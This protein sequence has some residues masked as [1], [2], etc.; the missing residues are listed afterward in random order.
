I[1]HCKPLLESA[2][3]AQFSPPL[4]QF[5]Q[6]FVADLP[7]VSRRG[8]VRLRVG[9]RGECGLWLDFSNEDIRDVL[10]EECWLTRTL[11]R[12]WIVEMGQRRKRVTAGDEG[13]RFR[14]IDPVLAP[15]F[16]TWVYGEARDLFATVGT[17]TQPGLRANRKLVQ[18]VVELIRQRQKNRRTAVEFGCGIGNFTLPLASLFQNVSVF[19]TDRLALDGLTQGLRA[20]GL[21]ERVAIHAGDFIRGSQKVDIGEPDLILVDPPRSGLGKFLDILQ[22]PA[23]RRADWI[24]ISC[25][26]ESLGRD[27]QT[28]REAGLT[29]DAVAVI[30]QFPFTRHYEVVV[31]LKSPTVI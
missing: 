24:Y 23:A 16:Q 18:T 30:E 10:N 5:Y 4:E 7:P 21:E 8:S 22:N 12:G 20:S 19:E 27:L 6:R 3:C 29:L 2:G 1:R 14:L 11:E 9:P 17:F 31:A 26:P 25:F 28:L 13:R 15:W